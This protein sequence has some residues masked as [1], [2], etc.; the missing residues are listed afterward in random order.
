MDF[1]VTEYGKFLDRV[2][3]STLQLIF[4]KLYLLSFSAASKKNIHNDIKKAIEISVPFPTTC[5][6]EAG[7]SSYTSTKIGYHNKLNTEA[8]TRI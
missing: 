7:F 1:N 8:N 4:K 3:G 2:L 6:C 5:L